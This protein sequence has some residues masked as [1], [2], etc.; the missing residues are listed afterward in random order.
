MTVRH[1]ARHLTQVRHPASLTCRNSV[2]GLRTCLTIG[3][4]IDTA[5]SLTRL[6]YRR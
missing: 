6:R 2:N 5:G 4:T 3:E 1:P